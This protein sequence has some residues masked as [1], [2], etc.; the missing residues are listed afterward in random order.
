[1]RKALTLTLTLTLTSASHVILTLTLTLTPTIPNPNGA[2]PEDGWGWRPA[3]RLG[4]DARA[5]ALVGPAGSTRHEQ[6]RWRTCGMHA[7]HAVKGRVRCTWLDASDV[8]RRRT[9]AVRSEG[10]RAH[11]HLAH[12]APAHVHVVHVVH[13]HTPCT[14][15]CACSM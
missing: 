2:P 11:V 15:R 9:A 10:V 14:T 7:R 8:G 6:S 5:A 1:M 3:T 4:R 13:A 12:V